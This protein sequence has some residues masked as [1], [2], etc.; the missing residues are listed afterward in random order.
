MSLLRVSDLSVGVRTRSGIS[1]IVSDVSFTVGPGEA[2]ALV[3]ESGCGKTTTLR[4]VLGLFPQSIEPIGGRIDFE[5]QDLLTLSPRQLRTVRGNRIAVIWQDPQSSLDPVMR[6]GDQIVEAIRAHESISRQAAAARARELMTKVELSERLFRAYPHELSGGQRQRVGI[7]SAI[8]MNPAVL[9]ADEPTT[10][11]DVTVQATVLELLAGLRAELGLAMLLVSHDI[12][13]VA[14]T[15]DSIAVM[16]GGRIVE[17]G[18]TAQVLRQPLHQYTAGLLACAPDVE[19][20][21][22]RPRGIAGAPPARPVTAACSFAPRCPAASVRCRSELPILQAA[23]GSTVAHA[24]AC[25]HPVGS[26]QAA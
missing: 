26:E 15:C 23:P 9:L 3:G 5:S 17:S 2:L 16:Y 21:G 20:V 7:A 6:V 13:V 25:F 4:A 10:A 12:A 14:S 1:P 11:L 19:Q 22:R 8:S 18:S 24:A